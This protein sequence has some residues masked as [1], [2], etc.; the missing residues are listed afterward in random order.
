MGDFGFVTGTGGW[1][2]EIGFGMTGDEVSGCCDKTAGI[3][4][5]GDAIGRTATGV[6]ATGGGAIGAGATGGGSTGFGPDHMS[7]TGADSGTR[8]TTVFDPG[9]GT[10]PEPGSDPG[11]D[12][13]ERSGPEAGFPSG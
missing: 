5:G 10:G 3:A 2:T 4:N 11:P 9:P 1:R 13:S 8:S 7:G 6:G 12:S